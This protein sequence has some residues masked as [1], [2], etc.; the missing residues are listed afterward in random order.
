MTAFDPTRMRFP[1]RNR[2]PFPG[3]KVLI[4]GTTQAGKTGVVVDAP[5]ELRRRI[6]V[7]IG[8][9]VFGFYT[10]QLIEILAD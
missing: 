2:K 1:S 10:H 8:V 6:A 3:T 7:K 4:T 9:V 5:P